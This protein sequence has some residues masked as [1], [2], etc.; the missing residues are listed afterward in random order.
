M[1]RDNLRLIAAL[2]A[3][4]VV[5]GAWLQ[6]RPVPHLDGV[7]VQE[8][9]AQGPPDVGSPWPYNGYALRALASFQL[10][11]RVLSAEHYRFDR[12][13]ALAPVDLALGWGPMSDSATL[14][15]FKITQ[16]ARFYTVYPQDGAADLDDA[17]VH[18]A[19]MHLIPA[20]ES[21]RRTLLAVKPGQLVTLRGELVEVTSSDGFRWRSSLTRTDRGA[22]ACE[23][24]WVE[25]ARFR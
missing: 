24:V 22:G 19:N 16:G 2:L 6:G 13:A 17:M 18:S 10:T 3:L 5:A 14:R 25:E 9:P 15:H 4:A 23:L 21:V 1:D 20:T 7:L 12:G 8:E 11:A